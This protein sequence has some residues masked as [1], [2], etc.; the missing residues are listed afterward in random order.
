MKHVFESR[1][2]TVLLFQYFL[3]LFFLYHLNK[4]QNLQQ[5]CIKNKR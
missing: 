4:L 1:R 3:S 5:L 2:L